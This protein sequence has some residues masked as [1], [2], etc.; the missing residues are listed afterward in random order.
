MG[1]ACLTEG[2]SWDSTLD[3]LIDSHRIIQDNGTIT[4]VGRR[5]ETRALSIES[6]NHIVVEWW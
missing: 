1:G 2:Q 6:S 4:I 5:T 3:H